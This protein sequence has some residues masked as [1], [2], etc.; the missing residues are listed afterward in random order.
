VISARDDEFLEDLSR[1]AYRYFLEYADPATGLVL[2]RAGTDGVA[3]NR[4]ASIATT[5]FGLTGLAIA[6]ARHWT[7]AAGARERTRVALRFFA[8]H[9]QHAHGWFYH[10]MDAGTG[11]RR[12][13]SEISSIDTALLL[14]GILA[15]AQYFRDDAE[16]VRLANRIYERVDFRWMLNGSDSLLS[17]G[18]KPESGFLAYRWDSYCELMI[19][20]LLAIGS[21]SHAIPDDAWYAWKRPRLTYA[22]YTF[23]VDGP[24][25]V[26]QY[27]HAWIDFRGR[28]ETRAP[29]TDYFENSLAATRAH[30]EFCIALAGKFPRSYG[31][32]MWGISASDSA[33]GYQAWGG[34][35]RQGPI[36]G[37]LVPCAAAGSL[38]FAPDL[39]LPVLRAMRER[40]GA[41][42]YGRYGFADAFNPST[43]WVDSDVIGIDQGITLLSAEN[44]RSGRVWQWS[45]ADPNLARAM[46]AVFES[47]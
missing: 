20:Y 7:E 39:C 25:F 23:I 11:E 4:I 31:P 27:S 22:G 34:P 38:M 1:R 13:N 37:T 28:H 36:D 21:P 32:E 47:H 14:A 3:H 44:L 24:L 6:A 26:H 19:L 46:N 15:A 8:E 2:D 12:W 10:W 35:P 18:W 41:R 16:I 43:D 17:H 40:F 9:A 33:N 5:G 42:I 30:R 29:H 45:M